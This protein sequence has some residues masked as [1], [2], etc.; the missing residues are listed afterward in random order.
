MLFDTL[1]MD[2]D[3][4]LSRDDLKKAAKRFNWS[5]REAPFLAVFDLL[6]ISKPISK[7][8]FAEFIQQMH[9]DPLGPYGDI[10]L[11]AH[12]FLERKDPLSEDLISNQQKA[13]PYVRNASPK[14]DVDR[15][16]ELVSMDRHL[17]K[18]AGAEA[19]LQYRT[20]LEPLEIADIPYNE[21]A[22]LMVD[23]Q[24]SFTEGAW[25]RSMCAVSTYQWLP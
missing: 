21:A 11:K 9:N 10:L 1:D 19:A 15:Q 16:L 3:G 22:I 17:A 13:W 20:L 7:P 4:F 8:E 25:M 18:L 6:S 14:K 2:H 24:R 12:Q 5:W 23:P